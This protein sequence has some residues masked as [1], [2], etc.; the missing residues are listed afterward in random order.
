MGKF[1]ILGKRKAEL[2]VV[3]DFFVPVIGTEWHATDV[4]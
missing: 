2:V 1:G 4:R 3:F